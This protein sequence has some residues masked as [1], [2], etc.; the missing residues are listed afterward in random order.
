MAWHRHHYLS[1]SQHGGTFES[2]YRITNH[3]IKFYNDSF[4]AACQTQGVPV[5]K[6]MSAT[7]FQSM[8][9]AGKVTGT[10]EREPK[11]H[12]TSHLGQ[13]FCPTWR[14]INMLSEGHGIDFGKSRWPG[15]IACSARPADS[16]LLTPTNCGIW[17]SSWDAVRMRKEKKEIHCLVLKKTMVALHTF[18]QLHDSPPPLQNWDR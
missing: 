5:I 18:V 11:K 1:G 7:A 17:K 6:P 9:H 16:N 12:L 3:L 4:L 8:L 10:G 14:S 15:I 13:G 2:A